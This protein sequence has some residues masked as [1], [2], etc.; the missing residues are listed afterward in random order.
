MTPTHITIG[1]VKKG[2]RDALC[3]RISPEMIFEAEILSEE[4]NM[5]LNGSRITLADDGEGFNK[6][7]DNTLEEGGAL[8]YDTNG[9]TVYGD[10]MY[11]SFK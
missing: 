6:L 2:S 11:V 1:D 7:S 8:V 10:T 3:Y 9:A 5:I 4:A